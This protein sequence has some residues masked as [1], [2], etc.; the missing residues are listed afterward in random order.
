MYAIVTTW[1]G[2][3]VPSVYGIY[4]HKKDAEKTLRKLKKGWARAYLASGSTNRMLLSG[5]KA[6]VVEVMSESK[7]DEQE[8]WALHPGEVSL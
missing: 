3:E 7:I 5:A 4:Q 8:F 6:N 2:D 1:P